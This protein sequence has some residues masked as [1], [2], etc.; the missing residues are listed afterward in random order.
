MHISV[1]FQNAKKNWVF[2]KYI[3]ESLESGFAYE[4]VDVYS[5]CGKITGAI[6][7]MQH[8]QQGKSCW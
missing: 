7:W 8:K 3:F 2:R 4:L 1:H 6:T 5:C